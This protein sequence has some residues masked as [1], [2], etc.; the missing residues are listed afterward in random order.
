MQTVDKTWSKTQLTTTSAKKSP[1]EMQS[2]STVDKTPNK[3]QQ[4]QAFRFENQWRVKKSSPE[5]GELSDHS[6]QLTTITDNAKRVNDIKKGICSLKKLTTSKARTL[7]CLLPIC[8]NLFYFILC[9]FNWSQIY[10]IWSNIHLHAC[11]V[12]ILYMLY[13]IVNIFIS[14]G[15]PNKMLEYLTS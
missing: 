11:L 14:I 6:P 13:C 5:S 9:H 4:W 15:W 1:P 12:Y 7:F 8:L 3:T 10:F 2:T